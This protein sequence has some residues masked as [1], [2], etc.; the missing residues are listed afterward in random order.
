[1]IVPHALAVHDVETFLQSKAAWI[2]RHL[3]KQALLHEDL[4]QI[5]FRHGGQLLFQGSMHPILVRPSEGSQMR[6]STFD[7]EIIVEAPV[8]LGEEVSEDR[9]KFAL[10]VLFARHARVVIEPLV[11]SSAAIMNL[12]Y[13]IVSFRPHKSRWGSCSIKGNLSFNQFVLMAPTNVVRYV[14]IHELA[15]LAEHNHSPRFWALVNKY[16]EH[17]QESKRWLRKHGHV[18]EHYHQHINVRMRRVRRRG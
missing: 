12:K 14:V 5:Q 4:Q 1:V 3:E 7:N 11:Q 8:I 10:G 15:H 17:T 9:I 6:V 16:C 2:L 18:L 13:G